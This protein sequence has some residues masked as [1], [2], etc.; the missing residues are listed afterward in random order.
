MNL[1]VINFLQLKIMVFL[2]IIIPQMQFFS[3][4]KLSAFNAIMVMVCLEIIKN[5]NLVLQD[6]SFVIMLMMVAV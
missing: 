2:T 4:H 3:G 6:V 5:V 1:M